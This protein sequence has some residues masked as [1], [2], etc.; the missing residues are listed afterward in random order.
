MQILKNAFDTGI[1]ALHSLVKHA[2]FV[3]VFGALMSMTS[4]PQKTISREYQIKAVFLY[5]FC[6]FVEWPAKAFASPDDPMII[7]ILGENPFED[8]LKE[9]V[10][11]EKVNGHPLEVK[12]FQTVDQISECHI[13]FVNLREKEDVKKVLTALG[14]R[15]ILTVGEVA[16]FAKQGG[17]VRFLTEDNRTRIRI[18]LEAAKKAELTIHSKLLKVAEIVNTEIK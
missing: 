14:S 12:Y 13:L 4:T 11:G 9:T 7:G 16:N 3:L 18:N 1:K 10:Q 6:Q 17:I 5:N 15:N 8:Y 2:L